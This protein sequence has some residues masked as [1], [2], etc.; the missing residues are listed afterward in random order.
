VPDDQYES[1]KQG[2]IE[3]Y[4]TPMKVMLDK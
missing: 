4:W 3:N 1:I 2:W